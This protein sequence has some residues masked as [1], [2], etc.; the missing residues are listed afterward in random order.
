VALVR[1]A[2]RL[3]FKE[4]E[5]EFRDQIIELLRLKTGQDFE[6]QLGQEG[7]PQQAAIDA[8]SQWAETT[9]PAEFAAQT[10]AATE[11]LD[12]LRALLA[13]VDWDAGTSDRGEKLFHARQCSQCH[14]SRTALGPDLSGAAGRF[15]RDDLFTAIALPNKDVSPRYQATTIVTNDGQI[16]SGMIVYESVDGLVLRNATNQ[17][18]RIETEEIETQRT[19]NTS[20]MPAGLLKDLQPSD[21]ADLY[22]YLRTIA[23]QTQTAK[24]QP[25]SASE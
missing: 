1:A 20:L 19:M 5:R 11:N 22:A 7:E 25:T 21:L 24:S 13:Q 2:R 16:H 9:Y 8:W 23:S 4:Q 15:S 6:Y 18:L 3:G 10:G 12:E 14:N 17:T